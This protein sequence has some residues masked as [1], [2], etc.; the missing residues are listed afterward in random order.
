MFGMG[1]LAAL[2]SYG[3]TPSVDPTSGRSLNPM[4]RAMSDYQP[5]G[6]PLFAGGAA[7]AMRPPAAPAAYQMAAPVA[8]PMPMRP[9]MQQRRGPR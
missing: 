6:T 5:G 2:D 4:Q 3:D 1:D 8:R 7:G 9:V